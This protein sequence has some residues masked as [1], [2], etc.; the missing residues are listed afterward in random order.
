MLVATINLEGIVDMA[1]T[2]GGEGGNQ[3]GNPGANIRRGHAYP[4]QW[5]FVIQAY[6]GRP[7][8]VAQYDLSPHV[9]E[10][11]H[12]EQATFEHFLMNQDGTPGLRC[13]HQ[14]HTQQIR[15]KPWSRSIGNGKDGAIH[16][17]INRV[18]ILLRNPQVFTLN[19]NLQAHATENLRDDP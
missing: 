13:H 19:F 3:Q 4:P 12:K 5:M 17:V 2:L 11:V 1:G 6:H 9:N 7:V 16:K 14:D 10:F 18:M 15:G 8:R